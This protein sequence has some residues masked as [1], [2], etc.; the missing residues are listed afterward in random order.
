MIW[1]SAVW[2]CNNHLLQVTMHVELG[3]AFPEEAWLLVTEVACLWAD[4]A[5]YSLDEDVAAS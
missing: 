4:P 3:A 1:L 5:L 2:K